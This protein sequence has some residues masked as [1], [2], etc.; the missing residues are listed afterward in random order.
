MRLEMWQKGF[1][2]LEVRAK[3]K[4]FLV[5]LKEKN[6]DRLN[7]EGFTLLTE[8]KVE[9]MA[10][11]EQMLLTITSDGY[12]KR[13][14]AYEYR[15]TGRGGKGIGNINLQEGASVVI[16]ALADNSKDIM[17]IGTKGK[18]IRIHAENVS[19]IGRNTKGVRLFNLEN[20]ETIASV[21]IFDKE[22]DE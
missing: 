17:M 2:N 6:K 9:E 8:E 16:T 18:T 1:G 19:L 21:S 13:T 22:K 14:S 7:E 10:K 12:G 20:G 4:D 5:E 11:E 3:V 15:I